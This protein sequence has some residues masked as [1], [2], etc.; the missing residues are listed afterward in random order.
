MKTEDKQLIIQNVK[1][2]VHK[3]INKIKI[4]ENC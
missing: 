3:R 1:K 2:N 4:N